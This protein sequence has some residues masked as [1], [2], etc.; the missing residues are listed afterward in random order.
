[1]A[2]IFGFI[3]RHNSSPLY[4]KKR[5]PLYV[6]QQLFP[7]GQSQ[8]NFTATRLKKKRKNALKKIK[9][10]TLSSGLYNWGTQTFL[11][12]LLISR[13]QKVAV[14]GFWCR[15]G[16]GVL[17]RFYRWVFPMVTK[18]MMLITA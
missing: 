4:P 14:F 3:S 18:Q 6:I 8:P 7:G 16:C 15:E 12:L 2:N 9:T 11:L 1:M 13:W 17:G 5:T 10:L